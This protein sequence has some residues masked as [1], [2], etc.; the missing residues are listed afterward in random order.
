MTTLA[1]LSIRMHDLELK[2]DEV[3][4]D[5]ARFGAPEQE[6]EAEY[7]EAWIEMLF[8]ILSCLAE[9]D[10]EELKRLDSARRWFNE[11]FDLWRNKPGTRVLHWKR[12]L[13]A[14]LAYVLP[15]EIADQAPITVWDPW[16]EEVTR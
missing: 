5:L 4:R 3:L 16:R 11:S 6:A 13:A 12:G 2:E 8:A 1:E 9:D 14:R 7:I 10:D 15:P